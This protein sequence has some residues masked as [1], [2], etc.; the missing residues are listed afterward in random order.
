MRTLAFPL[1]VLLAAPAV[2]AAAELSSKYTDWAAGPVSVAFTNAERES[3]KQVA[4]DQDADTWARL[5]WA[6]R[7][8]DPKTPDNEFRT[9]LEARIA[10]ADK[11]FAGAAGRGALTDP[12]KAFLVFG[13]PSRVVRLTPS[14]PDDPNAGGS[15]DDDSMLG[16]MSA[17]GPGME[18]WIWD[19]DKRPK[20]LAKGRLEIRFVP[21]KGG[22]RVFADPSGAA[23]AMEAENA[24][25]VLHPEMTAADVK[26]QAAPPPTTTA[27]PAA[28]GAATTA[29]AKPAEPWHAQPIAPATVEA[30][31]AAVP[32]ADAKPK[33]GGPDLEAGAFQTY[34]E[35]W[36]IELQV[37]QP[38]AQAAGQRVA[39][40]V[41][42]DGAAVHAFELADAWQ[43][44]GGEAYLQGAV[45]VEPGAYQVVAG[46]VDATGKV[47]WAAKKAV[48]VPADSAAPWM[49]DLYLTQHIQPLAD[50][51]RQEMLEPFTWM[52]V[53]VV[54]QGDDRFAQGSTIWLYAHV[55]N[56]KVD[57]ATQKPTL[58]TVLYL[59]GTKKFRGR[60]PMEATSV[61]P[62]CWALNQS[63]DLVPATFPPGDY[64]MKLELSDGAGG[65]KLSASHPFT[66]VK[67]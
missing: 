34:D 51:R 42:R 57:P 18:T 61:N 63:L 65:A 49:S 46:I 11:Q 30:L 26:A 40:E 8:P 39:V 37:A 35:K 47:T 12:G 20:S 21:G 41:T 58:Q 27:A 50:N 48:T 1:L 59:S 66:V 22:T 67:P 19:G 55:C 13:K 5:F 25:H 24:A 31:R 29:A 62:N 14:G 23:K 33:A 28:A 38:A 17:G 43:T 32:P 36:A 54:P 3:W 15:E 16:G 10:G 56:A 7:D 4:S 52:S 44:I 2:P 53:N 6:K 45:P 60:I 64:E 9:E